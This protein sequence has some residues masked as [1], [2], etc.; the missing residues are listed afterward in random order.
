MK[1]LTSKIFHCQKEGSN[2]I[3]ILSID[4]NYGRYKL[5]G[6]YGRVTSERLHS[7]L[8][9]EYD[10]EID[11]NNENPLDNDTHSSP[12]G[13]SRHGRRWSGFYGADGC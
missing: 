5:T 7:S 9:G 10:S 11:C 8:K 12:Q 3:Y 13:P 6:Y 1:K 4:L 2:K